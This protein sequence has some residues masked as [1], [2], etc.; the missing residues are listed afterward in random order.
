MFRISP[1]S[2]HTDLQTLF[3]CRNARKN[4]AFSVPGNRSD[5]GS[6]TV[7][8]HQSL[9]KVLFPFADITDTITDI[10]QF[11]ADI[12]DTITDILRTFSE[13]SEL[14]PSFF[15]PISELRRRFTRMKLSDSIN[16]GSGSSYSAAGCLIRRP[17]RQAESHLRQVL[18]QAESYLRQVLRQAPAL[19]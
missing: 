2:G 6:H 18:R 13:F 12:T 15:T 19:P 3:S 14:P 9:E 1:F 8:Q 11:F 17:F 5:S 16:S 4:R 10:L 7:F